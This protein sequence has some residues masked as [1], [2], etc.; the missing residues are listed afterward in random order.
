MATECPRHSEL[1]YTE[2]RARAGIGIGGEISPSIGVVY[3]EI[4]GDLKTD[5][6]GLNS[7][8]ES[9]AAAAFLAFEGA[10]TQGVYYRVEWL[11][12]KTSKKDNLEGLTFS[13]GGRF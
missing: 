6:L 10:A 8:I 13:I 12:G 3:S 5:G 11:F 1:T 4:G 2:L 7:R 9:E